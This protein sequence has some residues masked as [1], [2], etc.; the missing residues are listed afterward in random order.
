MARL[1]FVCLYWCVSLYHTCTQIVHREYCATRTLTGRTNSTQSLIDLAGSERASESLARRKEG[2]YI[3]KSLLTLVNVSAK[4]SEMS[5]TKDVGHIPY[6]DSK[7]TRILEPSLSGNARIAI[8]CTVTI[9]SGA[10]AHP[11]CRVWLFT[12]GR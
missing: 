11:R 9:A 6:R 5:I 1:P 7:L 8:I 12:S 2:G 3:N 10:A 4:L